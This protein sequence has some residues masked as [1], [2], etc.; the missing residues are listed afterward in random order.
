M[1]LLFQEY[2]K[3]SYSCPPTGWI[4]QIGWVGGGSRVGA[5]GTDFQFVWTGKNNYANCVNRHKIYVNRCEPVWKFMWP[6][7]TENMHLWVPPFNFCEPAENIMWTGV[8]RRENLCEPE[9]TGVKIYV[10]RSEP[11]WKFMWTG[12]NWQ[13]AFVSA[14]FFLIFVTR[15]KILCEPVRTGSEKYVNR[16]E[17]WF[18]LTESLVWEGVW[19]DVRDGTEPKGPWTRKNQSGSLKYD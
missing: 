11:A 14:I 13:H 7:W 1:A 9:W 10:N 6:E 19:G 2:F 17:P 18:A 4:P 12:V 16:C 8:N 5:F 3:K 15:Q